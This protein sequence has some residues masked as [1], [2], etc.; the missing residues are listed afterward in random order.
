MKVVLAVMAGVAAVAL[1]DCSAQ[2]AALMQPSKP[3]GQG[4]TGFTPVPSPT[5]TA[6]A[7]VS[8]AAASAPKPPQAPTSYT[9]FGYDVPATPPHG[10]TALNMAAPAGWAKTTDVDKTDYKDPTNQLLVQFE[11]V[12]SDNRGGPSA[13]TAQVVADMQQREQA[14]VGEYADYHL[15]SLGPTALGDDGETLPGAEWQFTFVSGGVT[16]QVTVLGTDF[17]DSDFVTVYVSGPAQYSSILN[18]IVNH[19][20]GMH[21]A[22]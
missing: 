1:A 10:G 3:D 8:V 19:E 4:V 14:T 17:L 5:T 16:R 11:R 12:H 15:I 13:T 20:R 22:G 18:G 6:A 2:S 9:G 21:I 7:S